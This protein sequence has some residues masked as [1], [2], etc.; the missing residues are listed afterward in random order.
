MISEGFFR[1]AQALLFIA[2]VLHRGY[3]TRKYPPAEND[4]VEVQAR[5]VAGPI[6]NLLA[7]LALASL[8]LY[9]VNPEWMAWAALPV[10][11]WLRMFGVLLAV[12]GFALLQW[13]HHALGRN[14]SDQPRITQ[15]QSLTI[16][17]PYQWI[18][19]PIYT[20]FLMVLG[21]PLLITANWF[22]GITWIIVT[23]IDI[24][25]RIDFEEAKLRERFGENY[26]SY[27][28]STGSLLPRL[29]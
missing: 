2:F 18:R 13:S 28:R 15:S 21:S 11:D 24:R 9:I 26:E 8:V 20:S 5:G 10:P 3:Y 29:R 16:S 19:H 12:A 27:E 14:W 25:S 17:G 4:T 6:A 22:I 23:V 1:F 7:L